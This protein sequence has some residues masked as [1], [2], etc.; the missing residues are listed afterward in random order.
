MTKQTSCLLCGSKEYTLVKEFSDGVKVGR[1]SNCGLLYTPVMDSF[2]E[3]LF[4]SSTADVLTVLYKPIIKGKV[5]HFR[6]QNFKDYLKVVSSFTSS[7]R[8]LDVGCA[9]GFFGFEA[10]KNGYDVSAVEPHPAMAKFASDEL[11]LPVFEGTFATAAIPDTRWDIVTFTDSMEYFPDPVSDLSKVNTKYLNLNGIV[12]VKV[13]NGDYF[14]LRHW[15]QKSLGLGAGDSEAFAP[16]KRVA[17]YNNKSIRKLMESSGFRV[18]EIGYLQPVHSPVWPRYTG[19]WLE[20]EAPFFMQW[21]QV[22]ARKLIHVVGKIQFAFFGR[23]H[24]SQGIYVVGQ[25]IN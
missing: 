15:I 24:F 1:C 6:Y 10:R 7:R 22:I 14:V 8:L 16:S 13:P 17:H 23:N 3:N 5:K 25:K 20:F 9:H 12:F 2:P 11:G 19:L 4:G 21:K 18:L